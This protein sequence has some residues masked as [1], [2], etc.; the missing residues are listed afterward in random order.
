[1]LTDTQGISMS[2]RSA[3]EYR[4]KHNAWNDARRDRQRLQVADYKSDKGCRYCSERDPRALVLHHRDPGTKHYNISTIY[5]L[6]WE[7][8]E[9]ELAKC[10]V[11]CQN[12]HQIVEYEGYD[13]SKVPSHKARKRSMVHQ[14]QSEE[15]CRD[16]GVINPIILMSVYVDESKKPREAITRMVLKGRPIDTISDALK[17]TYTMCRNCY[18]KR[19]NPLPEA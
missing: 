6:K 3:N 8:I 2:P 7:T 19:E 4:R 13:E 10:D 1:M 14:H 15:G 9:K 5:R 11:L 16:C 18:S 17:L 12:H